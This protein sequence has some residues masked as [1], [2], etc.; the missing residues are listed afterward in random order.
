[1]R[2]GHLYV[3]EFS[4]GTVKI[5][6]GTNPEKR[7]ADHKARMAVAG[8]TLVD[9]STFKCEGHA[10][11]SER[12]ALIRSAAYGG[13][14]VKHGREWFSGLP[15]ETACQIASECAQLP[16]PPGKDAAAELERSK[17]FSEDMRRIFPDRQFVPEMHWPFRI[18]NSL[19][20]VFQMDGGFTGGVFAEDNERH[21][22]LSF[23]E[24]CAALCIA[25]GTDEENA[26]LMFEVVATLSSPMDRYGPGDVIN[27][28]CENGPKGLGYWGVQ[29]AKEAA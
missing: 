18:A 19:R 27:A 13:V 1:M 22:G 2:V 5:G 16:A 24:L 28:I 26:D 14:T 21:P 12:Q 29:P 10:G 11:H 25:N 23:F 15:Y 20:H 3:V 8:I 17:R 9:H 4:D 7:I 6:R